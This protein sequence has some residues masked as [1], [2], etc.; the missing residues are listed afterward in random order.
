ME[1]F[2]SIFERTALFQQVPKT[3][4]LLLL[5]LSLIHI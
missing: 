2:L 5:H 1:K 4:I 3:D